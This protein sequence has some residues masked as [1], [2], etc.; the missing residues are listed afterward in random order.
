MRAPDGAAHF[1]DFREVAPAAATADM[2]LGADGLA[3]MRCA[4]AVCRASG[5][6]SPCFLV[7]M[8]AM[9]DALK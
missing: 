2:Y 3:S 6:L 9:L 7:L 1:L 5:V 8:A 4:R